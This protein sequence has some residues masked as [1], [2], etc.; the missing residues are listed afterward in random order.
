MDYCQ[1]PTFSIHVVYDRIDYM[2]VLWRV[3]VHSKTIFM[4][5]LAHS[6]PHTVLTPYLGYI[7]CPIIIICFGKGN[8]C[9]EIL[10]VNLF[11]QE[12]FLL[13]KIKCFIHFLPLIESIISHVWLFMIISHV[14]IIMKRIRVHCSIF[15]EQ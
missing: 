6:L 14:S 2:V 4:P 8:P 1:F 9:S 11:I 12:V 5:Y 7:I 3:S 10:Y 15:V 13:Y